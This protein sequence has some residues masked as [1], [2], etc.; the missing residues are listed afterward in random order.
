MFLLLIILSKIIDILNKFTLNYYIHL[1]LEKFI[2]YLLPYLKKM[3]CTYILI[4][5]FKLNIL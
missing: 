3:Q 5:Y 1:I 4:N 2:K